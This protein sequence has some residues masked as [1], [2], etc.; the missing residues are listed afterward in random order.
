MT[1]LAFLYSGCTEP[2]SNGLNSMAP[3]AAAPAAPSEAT[4]GGEH[5]AL[6][7]PIVPQDVFT[8]GDPVPKPPPGHDEVYEG[9]PDPPADQTH[10][11]APEHDPPADDPEPPVDDPDPPV[12]DP[13]PPKDDPDPPVDDP[14]PPKDDPDPPTDDPEPDPIEDGPTPTFEPVYVEIL[15]MESWSTGFNAVMSVTNNSEADVLAWTLVCTFDFDIVSAWN[16]MMIENVNQYT[17]VGQPW[18]AA[19]PMGETIDGIGWSA[20]GDF[21]AYSAMDCTFNDIPIVPKLGLAK[22]DPPAVE[23]EAPVPAVL[24]N[25]VGYLPS[26][27]KRAAIRDGSK[28]PLDWTITHP[29]SGAVMTGKTTVFGQDK[30]SGDHVHHADFSSL[31]V[32]AGYVLSIGDV[33]EDDEAAE[34]QN[35][36]YPFDVGKSL[37]ATMKYD[38]L[39][40][41]YHNRSGIA[42]K[43]PFAGGTQWVRPA[44]HADDDS[45]PCYQGTG[46]DYSLDV[47]GGWYD[48]GDHGKYVVNGGISVWTLLNLYERSK[49]LGKSTAA[50]ADGKMN[51]PESDNGVSDLLDEARWQLEF[52]MKMQVPSGELMAG[53]VHHKIHDEAWTGI[54]TAPH[55]DKMDR[56]LYPPSTAATYNMA[57]TAAQCARI[58]V[59][60]DPEFASLCL[61]AAET[62]WAAAQL[63]P[64]EYAESWYT[65]GGPY[66]D[67]D[68]TDEKY[69]A[70]A[71]LFI[72]TGK[73]KYETVVKTSKYFKI[74]PV[75]LKQEGTGPMTWQSTQ[76]LGTLSLAVSPNK[77]PAADKASMQMNVIAA[78][79]IYLATLE[80]QGYLTPFENTS[81]GYPWGSNSFV[82]NEMIIIALAGDFTGSNKYRDGV[83]E[84]MDYLLGRNPM[85]KSYVTGYGDNPLKHPHHRF[86]ANQINADYP[87]PPPGA[88]SGGPNSSLQDP[89]AQGAGLPGCA[90]QKCFVDHIESWSTN[91]VTINWNAPFA[92]VSAWLDEH[93]Q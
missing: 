18:N 30:A 24:V 33:D 19:I 84:S 45:V 37:Y 48:A 44:G 88:I 40:Y 9:E 89:Y 76:A 92:W 54:P 41:F 26:A 1:A 50:F 25:Q 78:A 62:A 11:P 82:L 16:A 38:A 49:F 69:W 51:I 71:E 8:P 17:F 61:E 35:Q 57:A 34:D 15:E 55:E 72:T 75:T 66:D 47:S 23:P 32:G 93:A 7:S 4:A 90:A 58:W 59:S 73:S 77:L 86:W 21:N 27:P 3:G 74:I 20:N 91:E 79:D 14:D 10:D 5:P 31:G 60:I 39:A 80:G 87:A 68:V 63:H 65:G 22:P 28:T 6:P 56:F 2:V 46:C 29:T 42:I 81:G 85:G 52:M 83:A 67:T 43:M 13:D 36:S 70:A 12:D 53:M 64:A